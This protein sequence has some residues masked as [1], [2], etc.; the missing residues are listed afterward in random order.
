MQGDAHDGIRV[1]VGKACQI[2]DALLCPLV[3]GDVTS[4]GHDTH[5]SSL[6]IPERHLC[7]QGPAPATLAV[8]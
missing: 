3:L 2:L 6:S 4:R 1:L 8:E 7:R 5:D